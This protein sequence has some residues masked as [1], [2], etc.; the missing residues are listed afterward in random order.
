[1]QRKTKLF[2]SI[3]SLVFAAVLVIVVNLTTYKVNASSGIDDFISRCYEVALQR[4]PDEQGKNYWKELLKDKKR[5]GATMADEFILGKEYTERNKSDDEFIKDLYAMFMG[6]EPE[7]DG[8]NY[9]INNI[10]NG[11]NRREV[12]AGFA[13]S[14]EF[15]NICN[16]FGIPAGY[17]DANCST[18]Q[19]NNI[20]LFVDRMY[21][22]SLGRGGEY[23]GQQYWVKGLMA[24][25]LTGSECAA[26][27][28]NSPEYKNL[29]LSDSKY[30]ENLYYA[31]M[32]R[33]SDADGKRYWVNNLKNGIMTRDQV[34][35]GFSESQEFK[36]IC[37]SYNIPVGQYIATDVIDPNIV[38]F[39][40]YV[41]E[42][43]MAEGFNDYNSDIQRIITQ[44]TGVSV[45]YS[46]FQ[47]SKNETESIKK[48][49]KE[50]DLPDYL[51]VSE[52]EVANY[53]YQ[54]GYLVPWD[55]YLA[56]Y[57]NLKSL[58]SDEEW[59]YFRRPDG[60]IYWVD[61]Y[62]LANKGEYKDTIHNDSAF[63]IQ[64]RVLEWAGYPNIETLDEY[65]DLIEKYYAAN[66]SFVNPQGQKVKII[67]YTSLNEDWRYFCLESAPRFLG[68]TFD[69]G[70]V[71]VDTASMKVLDCNTSDAAVRYFKKLNEEYKKGIIDKDFDNQTYDEY[72]NKLSTGAV[73]GMFD[74]YWNFAYSI[75]DSYEAQEL[76]KIGCEY[77]PLG[78]TLDKGVKNHYHVYMNYYNE[79]SGLMI[80][81]SCD[82]P[83]KA[84]EF[85]N[86]LLEQ[87]IHNLRFWGVEG[88]DY[89]VDSNGLFYRTPE[90]RMN[91][92]DEEY[93]KKHMCFYKIMPG[94]QG[95][96]SDGKNSMLPENQPSEFYAGVSKPLEKCYKAY[97]AVGNADML[98]SE[99]VEPGVWFP[100]YSHSNEMTEDTKA[101]RAW[102]KMSDTKHKWLPKVVKADNFDTTW[103]QYLSEYKQCNPED[104]LKEMQD[105]LERRIK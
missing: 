54:N 92:N 76:D 36:D 75:G 47:I 29:G 2:A 30:V 95:T 59:E 61:S 20:N 94:F 67:P 23:E 64:V 69:D 14:Q 52:N 77:V 16:S 85:M 48:L 88:V 104:F 58:Y 89:L 103:K 70:S 55:A 96:S 5:V 22:V 66:K 12:F 7:T 74:Q 33:Q 51:Y 81:T 1:M 72:I 15:W 98:N 63:W 49:I 31:F 105:E 8:Y 6:R 19:N 25:S 21:N 65:F 26:Q 73:L 45:K 9:W 35:Q 87:D 84:F 17:Y 86:S 56:K 44:K 40:M 68:G 3:L 11:M 27:F 13:N 82:N 93:V 91:Q 90:M 78:L 24:G 4:K 100:M 102:F 60:H 18:E 37:A 62:F 83:D 34:L 101:G 38:R 43:Y 99:R 71:I 39:S 50:N 57:P 97:N 46:E 32:G 80:T 41:P 10:K 28:I 42:T 79:L 53:L